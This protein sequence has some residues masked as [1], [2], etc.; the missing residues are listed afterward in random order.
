M[1]RVL[2]ARPLGGLNDTLCGLA[3]SLEAAERFQRLIIV[4][5]TFSGLMAEFDDVFCFRE[6]NPKNRIAMETLDLSAVSKNDVYPWDGSAGISLPEFLSRD[7]YLEYL[8]SRPEA[9][10]QPQLTV[11]HAEQLIIFHSRGGGIKS[12]ELAKKLSVVDSIQEEITSKIS[13]LPEKYIGVHIR[14]TD[15]KTEVVPF[16]TALKR[17]VGGRPIYLATDNDHV[18]ETACEL[19]GE[20]QV[21]YSPPTFRLLPGE[22][23]HNYFNFE[24]DRDRRAATILSLV[25]LYALA[26]SDSLVYPPIYVNKKK[27]RIK[28]S[29]FSTLAR[30]LHENPTE[31][32]TF[33]GVAPKGTQRHPRTPNLTVQTVSLKM[34]LVVLAPSTAKKIAKA[35]RDI[36]RKLRI[37]PPPN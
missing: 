20:S 31:R 27:N 26:R 8:K 24:T 35:L 11:D 32:D 29:G 28:D 15:Y 16:L 13:A 7:S 21:F 25:D 3:R 17:K 34:R 36:T 14:H 4:D 19:F 22:A 6:G 12:H 33:F 23:R 18:V 30:F 1:N 2:L 5:T 10:L 37:H 9:L